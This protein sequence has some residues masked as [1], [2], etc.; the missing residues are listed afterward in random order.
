MATAIGTGIAGAIGAGIT[1]W[2]IGTAFNDSRKKERQVN[3]EVSE[4]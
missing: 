1:S 3:P 4:K 2:Q